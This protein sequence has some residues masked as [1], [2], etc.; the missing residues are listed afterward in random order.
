MTCSHWFKSTSIE[1]RHGTFIG[2]ILLRKYLNS[3][4][5]DVNHTRFNCGFHMHVSSDP[6][7]RLSDWLIV[8]LEHAASGLYLAKFFSLKTSPKIFSRT[9]ARCLFQFSV[10]LSSRRTRAPKT[11]TLIFESFQSLLQLII[12]LQLEELSREKIRLCIFIDFSLK[13]C[14]VLKGEERWFRR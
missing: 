12:Q 13:Q 8:S 5:S 6:V 7:A 11:L 1:W 10:R 3:R 9:V 4:E 14:F 2:T